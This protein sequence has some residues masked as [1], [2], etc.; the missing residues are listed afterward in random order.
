[1]ASI[2]SIGLGSG[3]DA[4]S[5]ISQLV[6]LER[7]PIN[8]L[9]TAASSLQTKV[10]S[11]G[12]M[13]SYLDSLN[14]AAASLKTAS[15]WK[16]ST[17]TSSN[18]AAVLATSSSGSSAGSYNV[19]VDK[20][21]VAQMA[22]SSALPTSKSTLGAGTLNIDIGRWADDQSSF[23]VGSTGTVSIAIDA[24]DTLEKVRDKINALDSSRISAS[25]VND[26]NGAR[27]VFK[28]DASGAA[29]GF[30]VQVS[31][32]DGDNGDNN[33]LSRLAFD[34]A[35]GANGMAR[36]Q[37]GQNA[38]GSINGLEVESSTNTFDNVI[39]GVSLTFAA[40]TAS[41]SPVSVTVADDTAAMGNAVKGFV[42]AYNTLMGFIRDQTKFVEGSTAVNLQGDRTAI[43]LQQELRSLVSA[44][45]SASSAFG[46]A[47]DL[48][49]DVQKDGTIKLNETKLTKALA[50]PAEVAKF[51]NADGP[52]AA[53]DGL[54]ERVT[55]M[56]RNWLDTEG[57]L[58]NR[59][60]GLKKLL[61]I[62]S[63]RQEA[64][65]TRVAATEKRLRAQYTA[66]DTSMSKL[67]SLQNYVGQQ[68]TNW[69]KS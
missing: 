66:L 3:L 27:L 29:N 43:G 7:Q 18:T 37:A 46:R 55:G 38:K 28:S 57:A 44:G 14:T 1:M 33:G 58:T 11:F 52:T 13:Q 10:S 40:T 21:A 49:M 19:N 47:S 22:A 62:N 45:S 2:T 25:I 23:T 4:N 26:A 50:N 53:T 61:S 24:G 65:E 6:T 51:F 16:A 39:D 15:T 64:M 68:I 20:L 59:Q 63:K 32:D 54:A 42:N 67:T 60:E 48:G 9:K 12:K 36:T 17:A 56:A 41:N 8:L 69:N 31:D 5:I 30:R 34:P 35:N